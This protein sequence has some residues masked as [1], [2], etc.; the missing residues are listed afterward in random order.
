[1]KVE[2]LYVEECPSRAA[3]VK[4]VKHILAAEGVTEE[5][6]EVLV[7][8]EG[9]AGELRFFG[10]PTIRID[11][12]DVTAESQEASSFA[13]SCRLYTGSK[14]IGLPPEEIIHRAVLE[15]RRGDRR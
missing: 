10:S 12:R 13:L 1:M 6:H 11:G 15:A 14:R 9:M 5:I 8:D 7:R 4:L 3:A 2:V